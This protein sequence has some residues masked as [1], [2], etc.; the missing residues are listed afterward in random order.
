MAYWSVAE[1]KAIMVLG[2]KDK[3]RKLQQT[4]QRKRITLQ[5]AEKKTTHE[6][7]GTESW[8]THVHGLS[9]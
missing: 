8:I 3:L 5:N 7:K 4:M 6:D 9:H 2:V 1:E